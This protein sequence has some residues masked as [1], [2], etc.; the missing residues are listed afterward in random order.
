MVA[1]GMEDRALGRAPRY[2]DVGVRLRSGNH[3][4]NGEG[5]GPEALGLGRTNRTNGVHQL[6]DAIRNLRLG[7]LWVWARPV[8]Q[9]WC[10]RRSCH[11]HRRLHLADRLQRLLVTAFSLWPGGMVVAQ[12]DVWNTTAPMAHLTVCCSR[13]SVN[14]ETG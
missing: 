5:K 7:V 10:D 6:P 4:G 13:W 14:S 9:A 3:L 2:S 12:C 11:R 1:P 8:R